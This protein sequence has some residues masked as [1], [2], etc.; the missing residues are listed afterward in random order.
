MSTQSNQL[1]GLHTGVALGAHFDH[2][3]GV[4]LIRAIYSPGVALTNEEVIQWVTWCVALYSC[5]GGQRIYSALAFQHLANGKLGDL[6]LRAFCGSD[7]LHALTPTDLLQGIGL[8]DDP[9]VV[10]YS[11]WDNLLMRVRTVPNSIEDFT[12]TKWYFTPEFSLKCAAARKAL[13]RK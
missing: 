4:I 5:P 3:E 13:K 2:E 7:M 8:A 12:L 1:K 9:S 10:K 6:A 11:G